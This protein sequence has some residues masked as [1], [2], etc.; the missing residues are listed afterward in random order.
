LTVERVGTWQRDKVVVG[1]LQ[2]EMEAVEVRVTG[3]R[4]GSPVNKAPFGAKVA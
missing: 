3:G 2:G 4:I 1:E